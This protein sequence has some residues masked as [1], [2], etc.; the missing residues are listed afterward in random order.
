MGLKTSHLGN[1]NFVAPAQKLAINMH[2][3]QYTNPLSYTSQA[4]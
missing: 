4:G 1:S 3:V 2:A